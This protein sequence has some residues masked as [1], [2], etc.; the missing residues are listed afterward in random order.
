MRHLSAVTYIRKQANPAPD[1]KMIQNII[2]MVYDFDLTLTPE[3]MQR[4]IFDD[5]KFQKMKWEEF[6]QEVKKTTGEHAGKG[7]RFQDEAAYLHQMIRLAQKGQPLEGLTE[8]VL[9]E[10]GDKIEFFPGIP[11]FFDNVKNDIESNEKYRQYKI[12]V[13]HY[14]ASTGIAD[15]I[16]GSKIAPY[17]EYISASEM[18]YDSEGM[19]VGVA[20]LMTRTQK[21]EAIFEI[22]K[23]TM[24]NGEID[25]NSYVPAEMRRVPLKNMIYFGDG[26][27]D[28]PCM[29][30]VKREGGFAFVVYDPNPKKEKYKEN[31]AMN[32]FPLQRARRVDF[33]VPA[34]YR[35]GTHL[36]VMATNALRE[37]A[38]RIVE[39]NE[40]AFRHRMIKAP[41]HA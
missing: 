1:V 5:L 28:V 37:I 17:M 27:S 38:D 2:A 6:W 24:Q 31:P 13:E 15:M 19:P 16:K 25:V 10:L 36:Y 35:K 23:G 12:K 26:P 4:P 18:F 41:E 21:T 20:R 11:E 34:D 40:E 3:F 32:A 14:I 22:H 9:T 8:K 29:S 30:I 39:E 33:C 7:K